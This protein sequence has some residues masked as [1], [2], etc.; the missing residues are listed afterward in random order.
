MPLIKGICGFHLPS[1]Y[2]DLV[3]AVKTGRFTPH[4]TSNRISNCHIFSIRYLVLHFF[5]TA[6]RESVTVTAGKNMILDDKPRG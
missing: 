2:V 5:T 6:T 3:T 4:P 1:F